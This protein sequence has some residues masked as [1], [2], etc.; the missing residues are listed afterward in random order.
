M[1][2]FI[3]RRLKTDHTIIQDLPEKQEMTVFCGLSHT[4]AELYQSL[5]EQSLAAIDSSDGIQRHG[6]VLALLTKL[7]QLCNHPALLLKEPGIEQ[8]TASG[9]LRRLTE[10]LE[11]VITG[12]DHALIFTQFAE[13]GHLL[14]PYLERQF[15]QEVLYLHGGTKQQHR[16]AIVERFQQDPNS[17]ALFI[18]SL[19]AGERALT[20]PAPTMFSMWTAGGIRRWKIRPLTGLFA[21]ARLATYRFTNL[22]APEH[23]RKKS[24]R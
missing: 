21:L 13:W 17:P 23:W 22:S 1:R 10:M 16:Q 14:K 5:V 2:P 11:E 7:K 9:K 18:L 4:Q 6:L 3:L 19:K 15:N 8:P 20:S 24:M 12:G